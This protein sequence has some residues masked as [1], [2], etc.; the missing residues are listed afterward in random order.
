[1]VSWLLLFIFNLIAFQTE[2]FCISAA[3]GFREARQ[4]SLF[5]VSDRR[6][7]ITQIMGI[8]VTLAWM[9][10]PSSAGEI[11]SRI[12]QAITTSDLGVSVRRS[13]VKG[14]QTMDTLDKRWEGFSDRFSL[15]S[16]RSKQGGRPK[17]K[18]IPPLLPLDKDVANKI[19]ETC[20]AVFSDVTGISI[21]AVKR[22]IDKV[23]ALVKPSF[24]R[25]GADLET[26]DTIVET[27]DQ[28]NF[29]SYVHFKAYSNLIVEK[30]IDFRNF[31][32][33][34]ERQCGTKL[35][36]LLNLESNIASSSNRTEDLAVRLQ[37]I[38]SL[39]MILHDKGL[40][41]ATELSAIDPDL[42]SDWE[43][44]LSDLELSLALDGDATQN[45]QIL[46]QEQGFKLI[47]SY[48]KFMLGPLLQIPGQK[49]L[50]EE[51]YMDTDYNSNPDLFDV[52]EVLLNIVLES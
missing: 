42:Q 38:D 18:V 8:G 12:T 50:I 40:V 33:E 16:E 7:A 26:F 30:K 1:M 45:A 23:S 44:G 35:L 32:R 2:A 6:E 10:P 11:G 21:S 41:S 52:K 24:Q 3:V 15:G 31:R 29:A 46:L 28:F 13:V 9:P 17:P 34:F 39:T 19:L 14:A 47:P 20:D 48:T 4:L 43:E 27:G 25:S 51:Y 36:A 49:L 22:E 37:A 5:A